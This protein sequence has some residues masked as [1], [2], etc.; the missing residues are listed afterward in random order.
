MPSFKVFVNTGLKKS[1]R[2]FCSEPIIIVVTL[3]SASVY[4]FAYLLTEALPKVYA[5]FGF[6]PVESGLVYLTLCI[7][8]VLALSVRFWDIH[9]GK[10]RENRGEEMVCIML[11]SIVRS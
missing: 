6:S 9:V 1:I 10:R 11:C 2:L 7:G 3:M 5:G 8:A 4:A